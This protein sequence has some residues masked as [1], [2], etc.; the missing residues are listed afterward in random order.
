MD[1]PFIPG[2]PDIPTHLRGRA[3]FHLVVFELRGR[4]GV[5]NHIA[6]PVSV[7]DDD[8]MI[9]DGRAALHEMLAS[10]AEESK[11]WKPASQEGDGTP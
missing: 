5:N 10:L 3:E 9:A 1:A 2:N 7:K 8:A 11:I 4:Q 6:I